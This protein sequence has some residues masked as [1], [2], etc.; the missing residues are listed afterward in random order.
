MMVSISLPLR[1]WGCDTS[2][3]T[4]QTCDHGCKSDCGVYMSSRT[5]AS[6]HDEK[7]EEKDVRKSDIGGSVGRIKVRDRGIY[8]A[9][10]IA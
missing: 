6:S 3:Q 2:G 5:R 10:K 4:S 8:Q 1:K 9:R 7:R